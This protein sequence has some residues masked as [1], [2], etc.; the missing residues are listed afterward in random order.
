MAILDN[1]T[2]WGEIESI[3]QFAIGGLM[4]VLPKYQCA[5]QMLTPG[6]NIYKCHVPNFN[7]LGKHPCNPNCKLCLSVHWAF[8]I[9]FLL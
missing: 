1:W 4:I 5:G 6:Y 3:R 9:K 2:V 8:Q 7:I